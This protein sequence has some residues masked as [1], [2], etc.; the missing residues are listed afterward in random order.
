VS[1][2]GAYLPDPTEGITRPGRTAEGQG[3]RPSRNFKTPALSALRPNAVA[4]PCTSRASFTTWGTWSP[5]DR[6]TSA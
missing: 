1:G 2:P 5:A 4:R 3:V 6:V